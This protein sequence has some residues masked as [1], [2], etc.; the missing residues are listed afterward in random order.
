MHTEETDGSNTSPKEETKDSPPWA[1]IFG[2][3]LSAV[4]LP[5]AVY[6]IKLRLS[7]SRDTDDYISTIVHDLR[8]PLTAI[9]NYIALLQKGSFGPIQKKVKAPLDTV[10]SS[11]DQMSSLVNNLLDASQLKAGKVKLDISNF[12]IKPLVEDT[13]SS[14]GSIARQKGIEL[15]FDNIQEAEVSADRIKVRQ[16]LTNILGNALKFTKQGEVIVSAVYKERMFEVS[17]R[18]TGIGIPQD[19]QSI[20]FTRFGQLQNNGNKSAGTGLGLYVSR[21]LARKMG[22]DLRL[23]DSKMNK[24]STFSLFLP[25]SQ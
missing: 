12:P 10:A 5:V 6:L 7:D 9:K 21:E 1:W 4:L 16:I 13:V 20:L 18:D 19:Q 22:G 2:I 17:V 11:T 25:L 23:V 24:G 14:L 3:I 8:T 15:G